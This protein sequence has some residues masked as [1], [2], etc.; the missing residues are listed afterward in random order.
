A[1]LGASW[2]PDLWGQ[3]RRGIE[4]SQ[5]L[6]QSSDALLAGVRLS[7]SAS[8]ASNYLSLRQ[9]DMDIRLLQEQQRITQRLQD[10]TQ[11]A[12]VQGTASN[13]QLLLIQDQL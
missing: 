10:M 9:L 5:A 2:E 7:I 8:V 1:T 4:S 11:A 3:V 13:D 6:A 12:Y